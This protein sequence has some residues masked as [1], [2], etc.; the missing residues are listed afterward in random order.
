MLGTDGQ[1]NFDLF[2]KDGLH[3]NTTG[4]KLWTDLVSG[5]LEKL[6]IKASTRKTPAD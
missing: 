3:L 6:P 5:E 1:P 4:Y 2:I